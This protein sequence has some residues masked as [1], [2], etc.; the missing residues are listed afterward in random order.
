MTALARKS[1]ETGL[2]VS[3][4]VVDIAT[5]RAAVGG[6]TVIMTTRQAHA[7]RAALD[8][9]MTRGPLTGPRLACLRAMRD[10]EDETGAAVSMRALGQRLGGRTSAT[11]YELVQA[12]VRTGYVNAG[13]RHMA[14]RYR[15]N[16][17]EAKTTET[18][19]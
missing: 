1:S 5:V 13:P 6:Q 12:L 19:T 2:G 4:E 8:G 17:D 15:V 16:R 14:G 11:V 9:A 3:V 7:L 18:T 10:L